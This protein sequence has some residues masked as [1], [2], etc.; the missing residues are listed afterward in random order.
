MYQVRHYYTDG[1]SYLAPLRFATRLICQKL[2]DHLHA[3]TGERY[4]AEWQGEK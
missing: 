1:T 2:A 3:A 4:T